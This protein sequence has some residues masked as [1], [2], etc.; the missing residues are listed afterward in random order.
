MAT[1]TL[2]CFVKASDHDCIV[3]H[4][5][6]DAPSDPKRL[7]AELA[8]SAQLGGLLRKFYSTGQ[9]DILDQLSNPFPGPYPNGS[10]LLLGTQSEDLKCSISVQVKFQPHHNVMTDSQVHF[11]DAGGKKPARLLFCEFID[12]SIEAFRRWPDAPPATKQTPQT[13]EV[14]LVYRQCEYDSSTGLYKKL[15]HVLV[16]DYGPGMTETQLGEWAQMANP[17]NERKEKEGTGT[18]LCHADGMLGRFGAGSKK[19]G[20]LYGATVRAV[21]SHAE[22]KGKSP[23]RSNTVYEMQ[24]S[25]N[26]FKARKGSGEDWFQTDSARGCT[27]IPLDT[28]PQV[29]DACRPP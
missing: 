10:T 19:A 24:L 3:V 6:E 25:E 5:P 1:V 15:Q 29:H 28:H 13:I 21:T 2:R 26:E 12:N 9:W 22:G 7:R 14:H 16:V 8:K 17:T 18:E 23:G 27:T 20:F 11:H 4:V